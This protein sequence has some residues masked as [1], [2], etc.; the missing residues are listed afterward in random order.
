VSHLK[1]GVFPPNFV[2]YREFGDSFQ[3]NGQ[4]YSN[5]QSLEKKNLT[6][7]TEKKIP[8]NKNSA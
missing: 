6:K 7:E 2:L 3:K 8:Q 5:L 1:S 4:N